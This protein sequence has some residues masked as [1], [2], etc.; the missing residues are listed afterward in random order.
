MQVPPFYS[1]ENEI[2]K[3]IHLLKI[4]HQLDLD[5]S[6]SYFISIITC[7]YTKYFVPVLYGIPEM[8]MMIDD[9]DKMRAMRLHPIRT[10]F[11]VHWLGVMSLC[12]ENV[13][14]GVPLEK[15]N[16]HIMRESKMDE[17]AS[18]PIVI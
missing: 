8:M 4:L 7:Y 10:E 5:E 16:N 17:M 15:T 12:Q 1:E 2:Q 6:F 14:L 13:L 9:D 11:R 18:S 3:G